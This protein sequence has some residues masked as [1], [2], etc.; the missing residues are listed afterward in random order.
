MSAIFSI[1]YAS[2]IPLLVG[3]FHVKCR[4]LADDIKNYKNISSR[5]DHIIQTATNAILVTGQ[6]S[7]SSHFQ[8]K[9]RTCFILGSTLI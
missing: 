7:G 5:G 1:V 3:Q 2:E 4:L 8:A 6:Q 9:N